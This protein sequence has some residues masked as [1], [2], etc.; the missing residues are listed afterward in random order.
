MA[1][2]S[3]IIDDEEPAR[4]RLRRLLKKHSH[5]IDVIDEAADGDEALEKIELLKPEIIFLDI[6]MP[7]MSGFELLEKLEHLPVVIFTTA[8]EQYAL[9]AFEVNTIDYLLKPIEA[10]RLKASILKIERLITNQSKEQIT[11]LVNF[12]KQIQPIKEVTSLPVKTGDRI[13]LVRLSEVTYL[14]AKDKYVTLHTK[15]GKEHIT[16]ISLK[17]LEEKLPDYFLRVHRAYIVNK[18]H[19]L[20]LQKYFQGKF[21]VLIN[22]N[23]RSKVPCSNMYSEQ[24]KRS[25]EGF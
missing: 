12:V 2:K 18:N 3:I 19:V 21:L 1:Y 8:Y 22:D 17:T 6:Q 4:S 25:L 14:E 9:K 15:D 13:I 23:N 5:V 11:R 24:I 16:D 7:G 10:E 20:E